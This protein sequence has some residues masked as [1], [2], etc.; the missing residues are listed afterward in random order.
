[1]SNSGIKNFGVD[2]PAVLAIGFLL[3]FAI[4]LFFYPPLPSEQE[5][6]LEKERVAQ[7]EAE[8]AKEISEN[9]ITS[10]GKVLYTDPD[11]GCIY[12]SNYSYMNHRIL[13]PRLN[14][15]GR[16][17]GCRKLKQ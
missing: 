10:D 3:A 1:M 12:Y 13:T 2:H 9:K 11:T 8:R 5:V 16:P 7:R 15:D 6:K 4:Y 14:E 17:M